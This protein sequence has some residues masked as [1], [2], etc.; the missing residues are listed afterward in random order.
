MPSRS[1]RVPSPPAPLLGGAV[2]EVAVDGGACVVETRGKGP[3]IV[4]LHGWTLD[5][6]LWQPQFDALADRYQLVAL[7]RRGFGQSSA[8][9][10]RS[11]E[12]EDLERVAEALD[13]G[14]LVLVGMSQA[15]ST[16]IR[17]ALDHP[18]RVRALVLQGISLAGVSDLP[19]ASDGIPL[20]DYA[21][22]VR[23]GRLAEMKKAWAEHPLMRAESAQGQRLAEAMLADYDG[24][25]LLAQPS[26]PSATLDDVRRL[27]MPILAITGEHDTPWRRAIVQRIGRSA[28]TGE[29]RLLANAGHLANVCAADA[30]NDALLAFFGAHRLFGPVPANTP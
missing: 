20:S 29:A 9:P 5:R 14:P 18:D 15:G 21:A 25:D 7:D 24:R 23:G 6:R 4:F 26:G 22:L 27:S 30:F 17:F 1:F 16:A 12:G 2:R 3:A 8:P 13:L 28:R 11:L 19:N 10:N